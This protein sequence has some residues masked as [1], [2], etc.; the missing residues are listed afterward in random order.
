MPQPTFS[1]K[2]IRAVRRQLRLTQGQFASRLGV[3]AVTISRWENGHNKPEGLAEQQLA[4]LIFA[5][6]N[7]EVPEELVQQDLEEVALMPESAQTNEPT[8]TINGVTL[9]TA[10]AMT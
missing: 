2:A 8:I 6:Q 4:K 10:Q 9:T 3:N 1:P 7:G 5:V